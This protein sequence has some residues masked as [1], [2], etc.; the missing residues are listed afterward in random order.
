MFS[1]ILSGGFRGVFAYLLEVEVDVATGLPGFSMVG[2][3]AGEVR[4]ARERV[5]VALRNAGFTVPP[6]KITV[7]LSP[8]DVRKEGTGYDL[9]VA[10]GVLHALGYFNEKAVKDILF[11]GEM[12][13]NG[14]IKAVRG[15]LP[16]VREAA[17]R[18]I[19]CCI[20]PKG[21]AR[22]GAA[23]PGICVRGA[24]HITQV[25][26]FLQGEKVDQESLMPQEKLDV[27]ELLQ[28][29]EQVGG[30]DFADLRGQKGA[31]RAAEI[32][33]A[34]FHNLLMS[35]PPGAGKSMIA[36]RIPGIMPPISI[37]ES[38]EVS[39]IYSVAGLLGEEQALVAKRPFQSPHHNI[40]QAALV[41]GSAVPRP[42]MISLSHRGVLFLDELPEFKREV[43]DSL[44]Q[45]L[46]EHQVQIARTHGNVRYPSHFMLICAMN[47]CLCGFFPD[48]NR[49]TCTQ[50]EIARY[51]GR[52][53]GPILDR[54]DLCV[55]VLPVKWQQLKRKQQEESSATIRKRV[56]QAILL[57][58]KRFQ[59]TH[60]QFNGE[61]EAAD[62]DRYCHL[63]EEQQKQMEQIY[64]TMGLSVRGYHRIL[65]VART[66][67]DLDGAEEIG[68]KHL[69]E[70]IYYRI[71]EQR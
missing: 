21:N 24:S 57:Q 70:A 14:E 46:E 34:G 13:L 9:P 20:V 37:E 6:M 19:K 1:T 41:G 5:Q 52:V 4:E 38:L 28:K 23:I 2:F 44:R 64:E 59:D 50:S 12:G 65:K 3:L 29:E 7:N 66:I 8:A 22:E 68:G 26:E 45:P 58:Q 31:R 49:C 61:I 62:M 47:P 67:A 25:L 60:Y 16:I 53:S 27:E 51:Q 69:T 56:L 18:G 54:I 40:S 17:A 39:A 32:A 11:I 43:L 55:E 42:G 63:G 71:P 10:V 48:R 36:K 15:V 35:G 33:A 30:L